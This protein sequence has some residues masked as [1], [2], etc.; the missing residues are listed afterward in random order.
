MGVRYQEG[1]AVSVTGNKLFTASYIPE[2]EAP[3]ALL[4]LHHGLAEHIGRYRPCTWRW[5]QA[6]AY[7]CLVDFVWLPI[8]GLP[9]CFP[10]IDAIPS[11]STPN[12]AVAEALA[13]RGIAVY[14]HDAYGHGKSEG[15]RA[16]F[17]GMDS[18][19]ADFIARRKAAVAELSGAFPGAEIPVF[20]GGHSMGGLITVLATEADQQGLAGS[21]VLS[22]AL[23]IPP[24]FSNS[25]QLAIGSVL[26]HV[27]PRMTLPAV[28]PAGLNKDPALVKEYIDD[29]LNTVGPLTLRSLI[30]MIKARTWRGQ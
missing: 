28:D 14:L 4:V 11:I 22:P 5:T 17:E 20:I 8:L 3:V 26:V 13:S 12:R 30:S 21:R 19:V 18:F 25:V 7:S 23:G 10:E 29:P 1:E 24:S 2:G 6:H 27:A 16:F 15:E 9:G